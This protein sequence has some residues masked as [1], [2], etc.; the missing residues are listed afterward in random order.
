VNRVVLVTVLML[1]FLLTAAQAESDAGP[2][3]FRFTVA[4]L[5]AL[6]GA[7]VP[8]ELQSFTDVNADDKYV[9]GIDVLSG[10]VE[11]YSGAFTIAANLM[12]FVR[13]GEIGCVRIM[14]TMESHNAINDA[15]GSFNSVQADLL[16]ATETSD[17]TGNYSE[18]GG[19]WSDPQGVQVATSCGYD[20]QGLFFY[21]LRPEMEKSFK[22]YWAATI[23]EE[24]SSDSGGF[25]WFF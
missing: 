22:A 1:V 9:A 2:A 21:I 20:E 6:S 25:Y 5:A 18:T 3:T 15:Q 23:A 19:S 17:S 14:Q 13:D 11:I 16:K 8:R 12:L 24:D 7:D 4:Q 10:Q